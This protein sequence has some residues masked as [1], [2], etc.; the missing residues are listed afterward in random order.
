MG[1]PVGGRISTIGIRPQIPQKSAES[2]GSV[3]VA[4]RAWFVPQENQPSKSLRLSAICGKIR[5]D[6]GAVAWGSSVNALR[7]RSTR[8]RN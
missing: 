5:S 3:A 8:K 6:R 7:V 1:E 4:T 2:E